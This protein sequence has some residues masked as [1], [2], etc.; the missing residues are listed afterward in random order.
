MQSCSALVLTETWLN[1]KMPDPV[2]ELDGR[3]LFRSDRDRQLSGKTRGGGL[4]IYIN[5]SWCTNCSV[6]GSHCSEAVEHLILKCRPHYL[7]RELTAVFIAAV[8][9]P[10]QANAKDAL[11]ELHDSVGSLQNKHPEALY[12]VAGYFNHVN[13]KDILPTFHQHVN[14]A[15]RWK[16][17]G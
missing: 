15:T 10:P 16:H 1:N 9:V 11:K 17:L 7:P 6:V 12:V 8:Y 2:F 13:L 3:L 5:K 4:C 14:I